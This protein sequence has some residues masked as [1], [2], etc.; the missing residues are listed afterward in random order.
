MNTPRLVFVEFQ[1]T[2][3]DGSQ[4]QRTMPPE[5]GS[6]RSVVICRPKKLDGDR[7]PSFVGSLGDCLYTL[8]I[9]FRQDILTQA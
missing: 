6:T 7:S 5:M 3:R 1:K 2:S 4:H 9:L 8:Y